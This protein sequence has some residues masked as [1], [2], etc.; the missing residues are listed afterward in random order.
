M[1]RESDVSTVSVALG[2]REQLAVQ[3]MK[4]MTGIGS[5][6]DLLRTALYRFAA[7]LDQGTDTSLFAIRGA[8][9]RTPSHKVN[10]P[11]HQAAA[12]A[13]AI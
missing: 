13:R 2:P 5:D 4:A 1:R 7:H 10:T 3:D 6:A 9:K 12:K 11:R 8:T